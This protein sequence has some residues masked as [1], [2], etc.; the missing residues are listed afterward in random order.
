[1]V[2]FNLIYDP[3]VSLEQRIG[4]EMAAAIWSTFLSD[5]VTINLRVGATT[6]L[7]ND[8]AVGGAIPIFHEQ[9]YGVYQEY[10]AQD[11][12]SAEDAAA[13]TSLQDGNTVDV[14]VNGEVVDGNTSIMLTS[15]QAKA[16]GMTEA[17]VLEDG[18]T[19]DRDLVDPT[20]LD[21]Y[22]LINTSYTWNYDFAREFAAPEGTL[23]FLS[24]AL[25]EIG[26][27]LGF[28]SGIDGLIE[29]FTMHSGETRTEGFTALDMFRLTD[30]SAAI[31]NLD[32]S[33]ADLT[34]GGT[35][36]FS[37]DG[38]TTSL[39]TFSTGQDTTA[40][41]DGYQASHWERFQ[42]AIGIMDPTLGYKERTNISHL[43]LQ[44]F[45]VLGWDVNYAALQNGLD[46][47][48]LLAQAQQAIAEDFGV[49]VEAISSAITND[50]DWYTLGYGSWW[51]AFED[52]MIEL[53]Y[54]GWWQQFEAD[55]LN[56]GYGTWWQ[57]FDQQ[58]LELGYGGWWQA[59]EAKV[60][61]LGYG[62]W[63]QQFE[64]DMLDMGYGGWWQK[65]EPTMLEMS[66]GGWWQTFEQQMLALGYGGWWQEFETSL[67]NLG[68]GSWWQA[69]EDQVLELGY[70]SWWQIFEEKVL[71][72][73]YGG[74]W[75]SFETNMLE[76]GYGSWWQV[77]EMGYGGWW[78]QLET[79]SSTLNDLEG[80]TG[81]TELNPDGTQSI[82]GGSNDD[83]L[84][85]HGG[86]DLISG[87]AGDDLIDGKDGDDIIMGDEGNDLIYG[88]KGKDIL[89]GDEGDDFMV[90]EDDDD[91]LYGEEGHDILSG[92][93]GHDYL[94]GGDGR[95]V[96]KGDTDNDVLIGGADEDI[97]NGGSGDDELYG[98][99][100]TPSKVTATA[101]T[102]TQ[103][104]QTT[105]TTPTPTVAGDAPLAFWVRLEAENMEFE[106]YNIDAQSG[107]SGAGVIATGGEGKARTTF[108]GPDGTYTL[109]VGY[110]DDNANGSQATL[111]VGGQG[112][113]SSQD[114]TWTLNKGTGTANGSSNFVT[115][116]V[117][118]S[119][120]SGD[121]I[122]FQGKAAGNEYVRLDYIDVIQVNPA[123]NLTGAKFYNGNFYRVGGTSEPVST[124][125][126]TTLAWLRNSFGATTGITK[127][128]GGSEALNMVGS[129]TLGSRSSTIRLEA[130]DFSLSGGY[131]KTGLDYAS[132]DALIANTGSALGKAATTI[133]GKTGVFNIYANYFDSSAGNAS[134]K[135]LLNG[136]VLNSWQFTAN[137]NQT[138]QRTIGLNV[139]LNEGDVLEIQGLANGGDQARIDYLELEKVRGSQGNGRGGSD[140][141][142]FI[143]NVLPSA[144]R[145]E[146][147]SMTLTG[148]F[149]VETG[150]SFASGATIVKTD[151]S[152]T[153]LTASTRFTGVTGVYD[154]VVGYYDE[155]DGLATYRANLSGVQ[156]ANW[157]S[158]LNLGDNNASE[159]NF[160]TRTL[161]GV[162]LNSGD[163]FSLQSI[164]QGS[165]KGYL[166]YVD[167]VPFDPTKPIRVEAEYMTATGD[168]E[169]KQYDFASTGRTILSKSTDAAKTVNLSTTFNGKAGTY[170]IVVGY[171]DENDGLARFTASVGGVQKDA[172]VANQNLGY[173]DVARQTFT[174]RTIANVDLKTG[175]I[176]NLTSLRQSGDY[177]QVDYVEFVP[178]ASV[179]EA[180]AIQIEV[181]QMDVS[182]GFRIERQTFAYGGAFVRTDKVAADDDDD[183][184][185]DFSKRFKA[186]SLFDG[187]TGYYDIVVG[188]YDGNDGT[189]EIAVK[190][191]N[192]ELDRWYA[193]QNLGDKNAKLETFTTR[194][195]ATGVY[196]SKTDLIEIS[197]IEDGSDRGNIDYIK[198]IPVDP[199]EVITAPTQILQGN[200][201]VLRGGEGNDKLYGGEGNDLLY[202][203]QENDLGNGGNDRLVGGAGD[204]TLYGNSGNDELYGDDVSN[205]LDS[206]AGQATT[207]PNSFTYNGSTYLLTATAMGW[208]AAQAA[209][210][211]LGGNLVTIN[212]AAEETWLKSTFGTSRELWI[213]LTDKAVEGTFRW[214][215]GEAVTYTNW[216]VGEP[217]NAGGIGDADYARMNL[218]SQWG[219][220]GGN[221]SLYGIIEI[222]QTTVST[223]SVSADG[224][225]T[226]GNDSLTGGSGHDT[227]SG[228]A[229]ND[230]LN[231]TDGVALGANEKDVLIGGSGADKFIL[232]DKQQAYY[233]LGGLNDFATIKDFVAG[234]DTVQLYGVAGNYT[235]QQSGVGTQ[236][237][238]QGQD[239][240]A[241]F[242]GVA[243]LNLNS[244]SFAFVV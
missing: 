74:W 217:N 233:S 90:G 181:E 4:F 179:S 58:M 14:L 71:E 177:G 24:M 44:A 180:E 62:G 46:L 9:N 72:L 206:L 174:T 232:G 132:G 173:N 53:G 131:V 214:I 73:G 85:G 25:H 169:Q 237:Y 70:G 105:Q 244:S 215:S 196:V 52:Q 222:K 106:N 63:W 78:Q 81:T 167:F 113:G 133:T 241:V 186:T 164:Q 150:E 184:E 148:N 88:W 7:D 68:Y 182:G 160:I 193:D 145:V 203:E 172:W 41:G 183:N 209:A 127:I 79:H 187:E 99:A 65:F 109:V 114:Y 146:A 130:E 220:L 51:Q 225:A 168:Y 107:A 165:D 89:Y 201:D 110:Y 200:A 141:I 32:G 38:G 101:T 102:S 140:D 103:T 27:N 239:L 176:F 210:Q 218:G 149:K 28:V 175:D 17:L 123:S 50:Q 75:Q 189:A 163:T 231:G 15:A 37:L 116:T 21:G 119:L 5:D 238:W 221:S 22:I 6:G 93:R 12:T 202:G 195:V 10:V 134:A 48:A 26:H 242:E 197:A 19:W 170:N 178:I 136:A 158:T 166:D 124:Q 31:A 45:D 152:L 3:N 117:Q 91:K 54:G 142:G 16:L 69:F 162:L 23:D 84:V 144:L 155:S 190:V 66:Y 205:A 36:Y 126:P 47:R 29:T 20:A 86:R 194:T 139:A 122:E 228:G 240:V 40:G 138:Y 35:S 137:D 211:T 57:A 188:Y 111:R 192:K 13:N 161:R 1:M 95:D 208:E 112:Q 80:D 118:V 34:V 212:D 64:A 198:F 59:F 226:V 223:T 115:Y 82:V 125:D 83:I 2:N 128:A 108:T 104:T 157:Q 234:V 236:L 227:L 235:Q 42:Q 18:T 92:G 56:L 49:G 219:D 11:A 61:E 191:D 216:A 39:G 96:L 159:K 143:D 100:Y 171:Y 185:S 55:M 151:D 120:K 156:L 243:S 33:V 153:G 76:L 204:D 43:D 30:T 199:P 224:T 77:F 97:L 229:G 147:E 8:Q 135:V 98:D 121:R 207:I 129:T 94:D 87:D 67:L 154:I 230:I 60:L 213:G